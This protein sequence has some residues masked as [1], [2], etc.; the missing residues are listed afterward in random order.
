MSRPVR[1]PGKCSGCGPPSERLTRSLTGYWISWTAGV[2]P[3]PFAPSPPAST[4][5]GG[6]GGVSTMTRMEQIL[7]LVDRAE[8][9]ELE[10]LPEAR[11]IMAQCVIEG[12]PLD[13]DRV[14]ALCLRASENS[15]KG[16]DQATQTRML[17]AWGEVISATADYVTE[18][19][20]CLRDG[21]VATSEGWDYSNC[22]PDTLHATV[23]R[24]TLERLHAHVQ[25]HTEDEPSDDPERN[26]SEYDQT[27][28]DV[29]ELALRE[30][31]TSRGA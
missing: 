20:V 22:E 11:E 18:G 2:S 9:G 13:K 15:R 21:S 5:S 27:H 24:K 4:T 8:A 1:L 31:L 16:D 12:E 23:S 29:V 19:I 25:K 17:F 7:A 28:D 30:Y 10:L 26:P 3:R 6:F 14:E